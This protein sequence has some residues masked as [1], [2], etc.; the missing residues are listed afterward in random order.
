MTLIEISNQESKTYLISSQGDQECPYR[1]SKHT[2]IPTEIRFYFNT[3]DQSKS[4]CTGSDI[5][6][7]VC[8]SCKIHI[9]EKNKK[10]SINSK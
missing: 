5:G 3:A 2:E 1:I 8:R 9:S 10:S 4:I 6:L 7:P